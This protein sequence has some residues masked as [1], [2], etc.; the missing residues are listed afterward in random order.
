[1]RNWKKYVRE[2]LPELGL[3]GPREAEIVEELAQQLEGAYHEAR[4]KGAG[5]A[6]AAA[7]AHA[8]IKD[9][10]ALAAEIRRAERPMQPGLPPPVPE[11]GLGGFASE[12]WQDVKYGARLLA[13]TPGFAAVLVLTLALGIG[14]NSM[15]FTVVNAVLLRPLP[16]PDPARLVL[17]NDFNHEK[18][19]D[20][21]SVAPGNFLDWRA[22]THSFEQMATFGGSSLSYT[23]GT[24]PERLRGLR[25]TDGFFQVVGVKPALGRIFEPGEF[26]IGQEHEVIISYGLWQKVFQGDASA[27]GRTIRLNDEPYTVV[28][29]MPAG[30]RFIS[31]EQDVFIP[32]AWPPEWRDV[33]GAHFLSVVAR[34]KAGVTLEQAQAEMSAIAQHLAEQYPDINRGWGVHVKS[35][36]ESV[37]GDVRPALLLLLAAV[38]VL[39]LIA[40]GNVANMLLARTVDRRREIAVRAS[41]GAGKGRLIRQLLAESLM[42]SMVGG[43]LGLLFAASGTRAILALVPDDLP[44]AYS[45][46]VD[47]WV[48]G[49]TFG[50]A[51]LTG[52]GFG[53]A[54]VW[55]IARQDLQEILREGGRTSGGGHRLRGALVAAE[56]SLALVLLIGAGLLL[57]SFQ[58]LEAVAPGFRVEHAL[59]FDVNLPRA[60]YGDAA[61]RAA[62]YHGLR[63]RLLALPG[64]EAAAAVTPLPLGG[65]DMSFTFAVEN[66]PPEAGREP[67]AEY[68][69]VTPGYFQTMGIP[70][71][72]GREFSDSDVI[73]APRVC[74]IND[75]LARQY[76]AGQN[77][78]GRRLFLGAGQGHVYREIVGV[79]SS[80]KH[81]WLGEKPSPQAY[82]PIEQYTDSS[83]SF[84]VRAS[85]DPAS[86][87][88]AVRGAVKAEDPGLP[89]GSMHTLDQVVSDSVAM[90]RFRTVLLLLFAGFAVA[91]AVVGLYG[92]MSYTVTQRTRE[93]GIRMVLGAQRQSVYRLVVGQGMLLVAAGLA[94]GLVAA[95]G[96]VRLLQRFLF[97]VT[98]SD[99]VTFVAV[100]ILLTAVAAC[101]CF[102][103]AHRA[104]RV[105]PLV[106]IR[107]E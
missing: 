2:R 106:S 82:E 62:F 101:A 52:I 49:F 86:L 7:R 40:C 43:A 28:G 31:R 59:T 87:G 83:A 17:L 45:V 75:V 3:S 95:F 10:P 50:I 41:L 27:I 55:S 16:Y 103:P 15:M 96:L 37:V 18:G 14:A 90:P 13:R 33:R 73:G 81:Y 25:V 78:L 20:S 32:G 71:V 77:P 21:F 58:R 91:L 12:T 80:V 19:F 46:H 39:L 54:P 24:Y 67:S 5:E 100:S 9:W 84:V 29:V 68:Y 60:R 1:M 11:R 89:L 48:L 44:R 97:G 76:F 36:Y 107:Y 70:M 74:I 57:G 51:V 88:S 34:L 72:A 53:L 69:Q 56:V 6:D 22:Q 99:P 104:S 94:V 102:L 64:V 8:V 65:D 30:F 61:R 42:V 105:D 92:V 4:T 66:S 79:A 63:E 85:I 26:S 35:L 93:I 98:A 47:P 38:A 23:G